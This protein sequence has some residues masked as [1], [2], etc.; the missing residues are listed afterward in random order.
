MILLSFWK[1]FAGGW[2]AF[3]CARLIGTQPELLAA[4]AVS[5]RFATGRAAA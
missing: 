1:F 4:R 5:G 2:M 3:G